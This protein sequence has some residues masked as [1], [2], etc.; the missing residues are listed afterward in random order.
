VVGDLNVHT[1]YT[2]HMRNLEP[3]ERRR[4]EHYMRLAGL[5]GYT[6]I[7][8]PGIYTRFPDNPTLHRP[9]V[10]HYTLANN[11]LFAKLSKWKDVYQRSGSDYIII[12][13]ELDSEGMTLARASPDWEKIKWRDEEGEPNPV[14][15]SA[16]KRYLT[17][18]NEYKEIYKAEGAEE[19]FR[20]N[21]GRLIQMVKNWAPQ[22][23]PTRWSKAW[24][25]VDITELRRVY[26]SAAQRVRRDGSGVEERNEAKKVYKSAID[27][28]KRKHWNNFLASVTKNDVWTAHQFTKQRHPVRIP[29]GH[30]NSPD[31]TSQKIM[32]HFFPPSDDPIAPRPLLRKELVDSERVTAGEVSE[33]LKKCSNKSAPGPDQVPYGVWK[34]I[35]RMEGKIVPKLAEDMLECGI[36]PPMLKESTGIIL[37]KPGKKD[38]TDCASFRVI[39]LMQT[40]SKIVERIVNKRLIAIAYK[41]DMYCIN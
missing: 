23:N 13:T 15:E 25:T 33:T 11:S 18:G 8:I 32:E 38:Y 19:R 31:Q 1:A 29:G 27:K 5:R 37:P 10:F 21:V 41:E 20:D 9:S 7:N 22:K 17:E 30:N 2:D 39:A 6:I 16:L 12:I 40:F 36:H 34:N 3:G 35:H 28:V 26:T 14:I 4:R 24:W